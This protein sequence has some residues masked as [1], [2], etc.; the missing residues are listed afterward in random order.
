MEAASIQDQQPEPEARVPRRSPRTYVWDNILPVLLGVALLYFLA[1]D[2]ERTFDDLKTGLSNGTIWALI[3]LG[4][5]LVY[6]I[7]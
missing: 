7:I 3:A 1:H 4:Y 6:V 2:F 5:A